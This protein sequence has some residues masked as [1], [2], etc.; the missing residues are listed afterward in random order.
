[1]DN[2]EKQYSFRQNNNQDNSMADIL[3]NRSDQTIGKAEIP[4]VLVVD[5]DQMNIEVMKAMLDQD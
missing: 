3:L 5:D 2:N 4:N 1:M